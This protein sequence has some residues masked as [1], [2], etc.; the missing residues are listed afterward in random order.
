MAIEKKM[1]EKKEEKKNIKLKKEEKK[2]QEKPNNNFIPKD[3]NKT[4]VEE[5]MGNL[6]VTSNRKTKEKN[7][8]FQEQAEND[9][10]TFTFIP[11]ISEFTQ[12]PNREKL[13][14][15]DNYFNLQKE[16]KK[17]YDRN[18]KWVKNVEEKRSK[19]VVNETKDKKNEVINKEDENLTFNPKKLS[20]YNRKKLFE[21]K[22]VYNYWFKNNVDYL[23]R[24]KNSLDN[25]MDKYSESK[26]SY[27]KYSE[28]KFAYSGVKPKRSNSVET[29]KTYSLN[30][31]AMSK[32]I[33]ELHILLQ[34]TGENELDSDE[35]E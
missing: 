23:Y 24:K 2:N 26:Y 6:K 21:N 35:K 28:S 1:K 16:E 33:D 31:A 15:K 12:D 22:E 4:T 27:S 20:K 17:F 5:F 18:L 3:K 11:K 30:D 29:C 34:Q 14:P 8:L 13:G 10:K 19:K 7:K 32:N 9:V 25:S